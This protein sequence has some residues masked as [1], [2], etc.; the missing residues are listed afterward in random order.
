MSLHPRL[1]YRR[2]GQEWPE[3]DLYDLT[4][5]LEGY[6]RNNE[7]HRDAVKQGLCSILNGGRGGAAPGQPSHLNDLPKGS[8]AK[9][10]REALIAKH[11]GLA[12]IIEPEE[13]SKEILGYSLMFTESQILLG[14]LEILMTS[15]VVALPSHDGLF[16]AQS[17]AWIAQEVMETVS[18]AIVGVI[19]PVKCKAVP[20]ASQATEAPTRHAAPFEME[21]A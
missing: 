17:K 13:P 10:L 4:G 19:L 2:L 20:S 1:A 14:T 8:T 6:N 11:P 7:S 21:A 12:S 9:K 3:G 16:V 15:N 5:L 18:Q